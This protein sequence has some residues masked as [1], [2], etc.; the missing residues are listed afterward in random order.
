MNTATDNM[1]NIILDDDT[2]EKSLNML[3]KLEPTY[4]YAHMKENNSD[5]EVLLLAKMLHAGQVDKGGIDYMVHLMHATDIALRLNEKNSQN[6]HAKLDSSTL[7]KTLLLHDT[8]EDKQ[9]YENA[10]KFNKTVEDLLIEYNVSDKVIESIK[11]MSRKEDE[12]YTDFIERIKNKGNPYSLIG[13]AADVMSNTH[14]LRKEIAGL[15]LSLEKRYEKALKILGFE[16]IYKDNSSK[17]NPSTPRE[18]N[19]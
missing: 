5:M 15:K 18:F 2:K 3:I 10:K 11:D 1:I 6:S 16:N 19:N 7:V 8:L 9:P 13:K 17:K 12:K 14:P 4:L